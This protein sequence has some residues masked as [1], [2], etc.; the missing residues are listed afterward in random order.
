[1]KQNLIYFFI[2]ALVAVL[3]L[4]W[5]RSRKK[6]GIEKD[7]IWIAIVAIITALAALG[8]VV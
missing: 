1:M 4:L 2:Y 8:S 6:K 7:N 5:L 3:C